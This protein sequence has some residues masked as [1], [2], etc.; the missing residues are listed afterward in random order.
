MYTVR[1]NPIRYSYMLGIEL[2]PVSSIMLQLR[3]D[4]C[5]KYF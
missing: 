2:V 5:I 3:K 4:Y 1:L